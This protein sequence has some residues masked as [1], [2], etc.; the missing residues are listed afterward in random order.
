ME[1]TAITSELQM[2][3]ISQT[4][5]TQSAEAAMV[6][7]MIQQIQKMQAELLQSLGIGQLVNTAA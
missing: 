6:L 4:I 2:A 1:T 7:K 3:A 5:H